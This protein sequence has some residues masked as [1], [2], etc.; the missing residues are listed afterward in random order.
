M[1][2]PME[3]LALRQQI[4]AF[5]NAEASKMR[6]THSLVAKCKAGALDWAARAVL[7]RHDTF[8]PENMKPEWMPR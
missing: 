1:T 2:G 6:V 8:P 7:E 5:L 4:A 3:E